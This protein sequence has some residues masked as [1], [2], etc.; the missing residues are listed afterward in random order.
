[1]DDL[2]AVA[3]EHGLAL[4]KSTL[5]NTATKYA[6]IGADTHDAT[7]TG[8]FYTANIET[9]F[10]DA[11]GVLTFVVELPIE[12]DFNKYL[13]AIAITDT[14]NQ[15]VVNTPTP[16]IALAKGIGGMVTIKAAV[17]GEAGEVIFKKNDYVTGTEIRENWL[18]QIIGASQAGDNA[19]KAS[20]NA[21]ANSIPLSAGYSSQRRYRAGEFVYIDG[22][23]Y[24]CYHPDTVAGKDPRDSANRPEGWADTDGSHPYYWLKIGKW[25]ELPPVG[26]PF[27]MQKI[28]VPEN[29]IKYRGDG[30]LHKDKFWRLAEVYP[31]LISNNVIQIADL[32][33]EFIRGWD[34]GRGVDA[35]RLVGSHQ[36][37]SRIFLGLNQI[38]Q[39]ESF[40]FPLVKAN[41]GYA[42]NQ[43]NVDMYWEDA[44]I[45]NTVSSRSS[46]FDSN[47]T[48]SGM[49]Y[50]KAKPDSIA[51]N[52]ITRF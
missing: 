23:Y 27:P 29:Y 17:T 24:E 52:M 39:V 45:V 26:S 2:T 28:S 46:L 43:N 6:L 36:P 5:K 38:A 44:K 21:L 34:D 51:M 48:G 4:L 14:N 11:N 35:G 30:S 15:I 9:S 32:R 1:M 16:K 25:L 12:T 19:L 33:G 7:S 37:A 47:Q 10:Y 42:N 41:V 18:P 13:Y 20:I 50:G 22:N 8:A 49:I 40:D 31:D 3:T